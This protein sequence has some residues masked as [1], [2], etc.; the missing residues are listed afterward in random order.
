MYT[1][2]PRYAYNDGV[3]FIGN[4]KALFA[5]KKEH[6]VIDVFNSYLKFYIPQIRPLLAVAFKFEIQ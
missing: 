3:E 5:K 6:A 4:K 2:L 1:G